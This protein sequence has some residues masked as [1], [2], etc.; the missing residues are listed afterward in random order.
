MQALRVVRLVERLDR[1]G[2][3]FGR[4]RHLRELT[5]IR[6]PELEGAVG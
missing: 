1:I 6:P 3:H 2:G 5:P 4:R